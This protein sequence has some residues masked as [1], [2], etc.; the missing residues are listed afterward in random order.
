MKKI[1]VF[2]IFLIFSSLVYAVDFP[3]FQ[4]YVN[5][6]A[7]IFSQQEKQEISSLVER[8]EKNT[9]VEIAV[10][11]VKSLEGLSESQ[12]AVE[13]FKKWGIGK[14]DINN[15]LLILIAPNERKYRIEVG[16]GLEGSV[17]DVQAG[18]IGRKNFVENFREEKYGAGVY[19]AVLDIKGLIE[20]DPYVVSKLRSYS[21]AQA[22]SGHVSIFLT[23][24][25]FTVI[26]GGIVRASTKNQSKKKASMT[27]IISG[28]ILL[29]L[30]SFLISIFIGFI[31]FIFFILF[32]FSSGRSHGPPIFIGGRGFGGGFSGGF[33]GF[34]GGFSGG[35]GAGGGW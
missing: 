18:L 3:S 30:V 26:I 33:G 17:T 4:G 25:F 29:I 14:K 11:T 6:Y 12:Y 27:K 32:S 5:D 7:G 23:I 22:N 13:I 28:I 10:L 19:S 2:L 24:L 21:G 31:A 9:S 1:L 20:D 8:I 15:G 16:Y 35:G 34:G